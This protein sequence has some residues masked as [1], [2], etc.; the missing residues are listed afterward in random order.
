ILVS[1]SS[2]EK[3]FKELH[4]LTRALLA[5][6]IVGVSE[7]YQKEL[8]LTGVGYTADAKEKFVILNLGYSHPIYFEIPMGISIET[9]KLTTI[10]IRGI[11]KHKVG[12]VSAKIR[13]FR[14]PEP[15]KGK[16]VSYS[17]EVI[18]RKAGKTVGGKK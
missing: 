14:E 13:S 16:G 3:K 7:G 10:F 1:R 12:Q 2:D 11:D 4:G 5:N 6:M 17:N 18:R 9:V 15:Y 8:K